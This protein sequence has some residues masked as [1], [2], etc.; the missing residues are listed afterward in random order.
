MNTTYKPAGNP[1][2]FG[3]G[4]EYGAPVTEEMSPRRIRKA[5]ASPAR[6]APLAALPAQTQQLLDQS[7][8][9]QSDTLAELLPAKQQQMNSYS[10][11]TLDS[12]QDDAD[13]KAASNASRTVL[14]R[15][16]ALL[17]GRLAVEASIRDGLTHEVGRLR[18]VVFSLEHAS[19]EHGSALEALKS[20][21]SGLS[22]T[23]SQLQ[24]S[25][26]AA[27]QQLANRP[28]VN[29]ST[30]HAADAGSMQQQSLSN[31]ELMS[32]FQAL[33][34]QVQG[35]QG[36]L[37][38]AY[39]KIGMLEGRLAAV[40]VDCR[41]AHGMRTGAENGVETSL[42]ALQAGQRELLSLV[43]T[44]QA[45][46]SASVLS[47]EG[48]LNDLTRRVNEAPSATGQASAGGGYMMPIAP[49]PGRNAQSIVDSPP[50]FPN[51]G[52]SPPPRSGRKL[53]FTGAGGSADTMGS[54][55]QSAGRANRI[56]L[57]RYGPGLEDD[58][59]ATLESRRV[60]T[61]PI[62]ETYLSGLRSTIESEATL[63]EREVET[64]R[65]E[66]SARIEKAAA[67][68]T[69]LRT[70]V[71]E[72]VGARLESV[73]AA[74]TTAVGELSKGLQGQAGTMAAVTTAF[75]NE[76]LLT[77]EAVTLIR[78]ALVKQVAELEAGIQ[79]NAFSLNQK[80]KILGEA[81]LHG[82]TSEATARSQSVQMLDEKLAG[83]SEVVEGLRV[84]IIDALDKTNMYVAQSLDTLQQRVSVQIESR[85][86]ETEG[87]IS[88]VS[89]ELVHAIS[90]ESGKRFAL[91]STVENMAKQ[92]VKAQA[93]LESRLGGRIDTGVA[94]AMNT[95]ASTK[96]WLKGSVDSLDKKRK[97]EAA[98][99]DNKLSAKLAT[100]TAATHQMV[101]EAKTAMLAQTAAVQD[102][103][104]TKL[105]SALQDINTTLRAQTGSLGE[106]KGSVASH[107]SD[108]SEVK[109]KAA[110]Q[111]EAVADLKLTV[112]NAT[113]GLDQVQG[114][115]ATMA[116]GV[117]EL[118]QK[119][120]SIRFSAA[121]GTDA[122]AATVR[123]L[124]EAIESHTL[125]LSQVQSQV[126]GQQEQI[127]AD[128]E[129]VR[130][131][132]QASAS[133]RAQV[134]V[135]SANLSAV[136]ATVEASATQ[137][138]AWSAYSSQAAHTAE[139]AAPVPPEPAVEQAERVRSG[140][141]ESEEAGDIMAA[142]AAVPDKDEAAAA[143][144]QALA[145]GRQ[146]R[147][148]V[149]QM[150]EGR[151]DD[152]FAS[153]SGLGAGADEAPTAEVSEQEE[154]AD[155]EEDQ[156]VEGKL[157]KQQAA[158]TKIQAIERGRQARKVFKEGNGVRSPAAGPEIEKDEG[159]AGVTPEAESSAPEETAEA[160][161]ARQDAPPA[162]IDPEQAA[163]RIQALARGRQDR[164][165]VAGLK[166]DEAQAQAQGA[167][168]GASEESGQKEAEPAWA[169]LAPMEQS[170]NEGQGDSEAAAAKIQALAR[171]R[172][173]R[174]RVAEM[175]Q[176]KAAQD[177]VP[178]AE[179]EDETN[180]SEQQQ[181]AEPAAA[182]GD[183]GEE[184][185][186]W[187]RI[188]SAGENQEV[189]DTA[190]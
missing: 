92:T 127:A 72:D 2:G 126:K 29:N 50:G 102:T 28:M 97:E 142:L 1:L 160:A 118:K 5:V 82:L 169:V 96:E 184:D 181:E 63:R 90:S 26:V 20:K 114:Q 94:N 133:I 33:S 31:A 80:E 182:R 155:E 52:Q 18:E 173:D 58:D 123:A 117:Q 48:R 3:L 85:A 11:V 121:N 78:N 13:L 108:L 162:S 14:S 175:K 43:E 145:R 104:Q 16:A 177:A 107:S 105:N 115:V 61:R 170:A 147:K 154:K 136:S 83:L 77:R 38:S 168:S 153:S 35:M 112:R 70:L 79:G 172:Q 17:D 32:A 190:L 69:G 100:S 8:S 84:Y 56:G 167:P 135:L 183:S 59:E 146:D 128:R 116:E 176:A 91:Q 67:H 163:T 109:S 106:L 179:G 6:L 34:R 156:D 157:R 164:K 4:R 165:K 15:V 22:S 178:A 54:P 71:S 7:I 64:M 75:E 87:K 55:G 174:K 99:L 185:V 119:V 36:E 47:L 74:V 88:S 138:Q 12:K 42:R 49:P 103:L 131:T 122:V 23:V 66:F 151:K 46:R 130:Q 39:A 149:A 21:Q 110:S 188:D 93:E 25:T 111:A 76:R 159:E 158:A 27:F 98:E 10:N 68:L 60:V 44:E 24:A 19:V 81:L 37:H 9:S 51:L 101:T 139:V 161:L 143:K 86:V 120:T 124:E 89:E 171:G 137:A 152:E 53:A 125:L 180:Q 166:H 141:E 30:A 150:R 129:R 62:L 95:I 148:R 189:Q 134:D 65:A 41:R 132:T 187:H 113:Q 144:I 40:D 186:G 73:V 140:S 45:S 57:D